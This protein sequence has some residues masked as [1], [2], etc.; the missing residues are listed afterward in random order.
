VADIY[1]Y[2]GGGGAGAAAINDSFT[3][4]MCEHGAPPEA[5]AS[6]FAV[7]RPLSVVKQLLGPECNQPLFNAAFLGIDNKGV[8]PTAINATYIVA[9]LDAIAPRIAQLE[10][11]GLLGA[12]Y[13]YAF[14]EADVRYRGALQRL[15][16]ALKRRWPAL[17]TLSVL[18]W[19]PTPDLPLDIW[20]VQYE[21]LEQ[22]A[23]QAAKAAFL[24]AGKAVWGYHCVSPA[25]PTYLNTFL[26]VPPIKGRLVGW[27]ASAERLGGWLYWYTNWGSRHAPS[28]VD[29]GPQHDG[30]NLTVPLPPLDRHG[31]STY[32]SAIGGTASSATAGGHFTNE[33]GNLV[34]S[35]VDGPLASQRLENVMAGLQDRALLAMLP[36]PHGPALAQ[37]LVHSPSNYSVDPGLL[38]ATRRDAAALLGVRAAGACSVRG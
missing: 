19:P 3:A 21:L 6:S 26:D 34:Y 38:E 18:P 27:L 20:V 23:I 22:P 12:A 37:R 17:K 30:T 15:F 1:R 8:P 16:G 13:V 5:L 4:L 9:A 7:S 28:A 32:A 36:P 25:S 11:H 35:G 10:A 14:D 31:R 33:D 29:D 24:A 2:S